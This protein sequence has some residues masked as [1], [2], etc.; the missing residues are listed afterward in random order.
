MPEKSEKKAQIVLRQLEEQWN[1]PFDA[2]SQLVQSEQPLS[3]KGIKTVI[4]L[5]KMHMLPLTGINVI[6]NSR[7]QLSFYVNSRGIL[8]RLHNDERKLKSH[9]HKVVHLPTPQ[10]PWVQVEATVEFE[11][12]SKFTNE[13]FIYFKYD[14]ETGEWLERTRRGEWKPVN[15]GD[16]IMTAITKAKRRAGVDAVGLALPIFED[17][18]EYAE[19]EVIEGSARVVEEQPLLPSGEP[20]NLAEL[21]ARAMR[22]FG[23]DAETVQRKLDKDLS[24]IASDVKAAWE[25]LQEAVKNEQLMAEELRQEV[26]KLRGKWEELKERAEEADNQ[27]V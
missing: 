7:G 25:Q 15:L 23:M 16:R 14:E 26:E 19:G 8:W 2:V 21:L 20:R 13:A 5:A 27:S 24:E 18:V 1:L 17:Y 6:K 9:S 3:E 4:S 10:E 22:E 12:G 11:D